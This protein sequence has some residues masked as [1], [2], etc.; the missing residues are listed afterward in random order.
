MMDATV[1]VIGAGLAGLAAATRLADEGRHVVLHEAA[2]AAGGRCRSYHDP[3][4]DLVIDNG[5]H[6]LL[7]GNAAV[8]EYLGRIG[9]PAD[10]LSGPASAEFAF[11]DLATGERWM[12]RPNDSR[13]PW[14]IFDARRRVPGSRARDYLAPLGILR[15]REGATVGDAM[16]CGGALYD[17][18]WRPV[19][20]AALNTEPSEADAGLAARI[21][22]ETLAAGGRACRPLVATEGLS[23]AFIDPALRHLAERGAS[24]QLGHR[25]RALGLEGDR[26]ARLDFG[27]DAIALG[28]PDSVVLALPSWIAGELLPD[29]AV[30][31]TFRAIVNVH[32]KI[33]PP[34]NSPAV[35]GIVNGVS[36]WLFAYPNRLS[37][38]ISG[39]DRLLDAPRQ[40][41]AEEIW[42]EVAKL[43][44]LA[45]DLPPWQIVKERRATFAATPT[46]AAR[47]PG[48]RTRYQ[49]LALA[50]DWTATG[51]PATIEGAI[52]SGFAAASVLQ[53]A[54]ARGG[55]SAAIRG[56]A[57]A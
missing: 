15:A 14:W 1:H 43:T 55:A 5:N 11:A 34:P 21:L 25:L 52:R 29:L 23:A 49:N 53:H 36:E 42:R 22:R 13:L 19:L 12:L 37:V 44:G 30:S 17:R 54:P 32:F 9:A 26:V 51:L 41:L 45:T 38:T 48:A 50:G 18:L 6:L 3:V 7:S 8:F 47:R 4:L 10:A 39:A 40:Q 20:L 56:H 28:A 27:D 46:E 31:T 33:S 35:L 2:R 24:V 16:A 57:A